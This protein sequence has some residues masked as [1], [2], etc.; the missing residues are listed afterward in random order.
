MRNITK[1]ASA[2]ALV[3]GLLLLFS[4]SSFAQE[5]MTM[6]EYN[7]K[8]AEYQKREADAK[9]EL[10]TCEADIET[11]QQQITETDNQI[12]DVWNEIYTSLETDEEGVKAFRSTLNDLEGQVDVLARLSPEELF[13]RRAEIDQ[14]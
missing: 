8:L 10:A 11:V 7:A 3:L 4:I 9:A 6:E 2:F 14:L 5:K 1:I 12:A 13:K